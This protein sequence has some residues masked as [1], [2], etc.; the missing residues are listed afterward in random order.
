MAHTL[1]TASSIEVGD[2]LID[3]DS[4]VQVTSITETPASDVEGA[5]RFI[6]HTGGVIAVYASEVIAVQ[7]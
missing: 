7:V 1:S 5:A 2:W 4:F 6:R 3:G